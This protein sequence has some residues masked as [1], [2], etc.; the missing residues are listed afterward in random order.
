MSSGRSRSG[1]IRIVT[2]LIRKYRSSRRRRSAS[3]ASRST[4]VEQISRKSDLTTRD[5][6]TGRNSCSCSTRSSLA[7]RAGC[8]SPISSNR[9]EPPSASSRRPGALG[10]GAGEGPATVA[11]QLRLDQ[12][13]RDGGAVDL[14]E[15]PVRAATE[16]MD[17]ARD[18]LLAS[19][20]FSVHEDA[21]VARRD[22]ADERDHLLHRL[23]SRDEVAERR[24][25]SELLLQLPVLGRQLI[26]LAR[27]VQ[28]REQERHLDRLLDETER[29]G[30]HRLHRLRHAAVAGHHDHLRFRIRRS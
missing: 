10:D 29:A 5:P 1:G 13:R 17:G 7:W 3:A 20:V 15:R 2:V 14:D 22:L 12:I 24:V 28:L 25:R 11:E 26:L 9:T 30:V 8:I 18:E 19:A 27:L 16:L 6:P 23:A 4:F 21:G